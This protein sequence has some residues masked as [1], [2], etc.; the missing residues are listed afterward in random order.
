MEADNNAAERNHAAG[1]PEAYDRVTSKPSSLHDLTLPGIEQA[2]ATGAWLKEHDLTFTQHITSSYLRAMHTAKLLDIRAAQWQVEDRICEKDGGILNTMKPAEVATFLN[3]SK[4]QR[5][6]L[7]NYRHRVERGESFL[8]LEMRLRPFIEELTGR[9]LV[10]CHG[11]VIR[12][13][14]RII[15]GGKCSWDFGA[16][17]DTRGDLS[18]GVLIEYHKLAKHGWH[19]R[20]SVPCKDSAFGAWEPINRPLYTND[21]LGKLIEKVRAL[22]RT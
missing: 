16:Y 15:M 13:I 18:N 20:L 19:R 14:D 4:Q 9:P 8:D 22:S 11:H 6:A 7:D 12:V 3:D 2:K 5:H 21:G 10:V 17:K 1:D